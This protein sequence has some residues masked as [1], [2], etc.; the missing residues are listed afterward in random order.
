MREEAEAAGGY[1]SP[2]DQ[3]RYPRVQLITVGELLEGRTVQMP[4]PAQ[5]S[6]TFRRAERE[7]GR[8][9]EEQAGFDFEIPE[10]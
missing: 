7:L 8:V 9:A 10:D 4:A 1:V 5:T 3:R 2:Y 6:V